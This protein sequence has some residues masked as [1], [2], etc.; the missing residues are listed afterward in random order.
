MPSAQ[1]KAVAE[2]VREFST[3]AILSTDDL[4]L[5]LVIVAASQE[6]TKDEFGCVDLVFRMEFNGNAVTVVLYLDS[7][8][9]FGGTR[10][11]NINVFYGLLT[12]H[13]AADQS[14]AG[15]YQDLVKDLVETRIECHLLMPHLT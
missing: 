12:R 13:L 1:C 8:K 2:D 3:I 7:D 5:A 10:N 15:V 14:I 6:V 11:G 4:L 9:A